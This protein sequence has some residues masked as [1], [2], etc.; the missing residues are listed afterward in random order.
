MP[1]MILYDLEECAAAC[2]G[3]VWY[4]LVGVN[5]TESN[6]VADAEQAVTLITAR[7]NMNITFGP[8]VQVVAP[9]AGV[10]PRASATANAS[11]HC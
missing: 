1:V 4:R 6:I 9:E 5:L 3:T 2:S 11:V 8:F 10:T 7:G